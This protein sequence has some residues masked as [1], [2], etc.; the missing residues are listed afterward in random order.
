MDCSDR[1]DA[2]KFLILTTNGTQ[3]IGNAPGSSLV[4]Y[5]LSPDDVP[6]YRFSHR[7][8]RH[9]DG[10]PYDIGTGCA[11]GCLWSN[12]LCAHVSLKTD[13]RLDR[14]S[15]VST[16]IPEISASKVAGLI[17]LHRYQKPAEVQYDLLC[18]DPETKK[19]IRA[20]ETDFNRRSFASVVN[21]V[22]KDQPILDCIACG[23]DSAKKTADVSAVLDEVEQQARLILDLRRDAF[24]PELRNQ[25][26]AEVRGRVSRQRGL[27]NENTILDQYE[28]QRDVK[29]TD[30]NTKTFRKSYGSFRLVGRTDGYVASENRIVDSKDRTRFWP[31]VPLYDEIQLRCY[32]EMAG[33]AESELIERFPG[34]DVRHTKFVNDPEKWRILQEAIEKAVAALNAALD[35]PEDLRR[36]VFANTVCTQANGGSHS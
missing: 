2:A 18:K 32:M 13:R 3:R 19:K 33:A 28:T 12:C 6:V 16:M 25:L 8:T 30:R 35:D 9:N 27:N 7:R 24:T 34:G 10:V 26:A 21:E 20:I 11:L 14:S 29:V 22:M 5:R 31:Q 23:L 1:E 36:I 17:G 15:N 4:L